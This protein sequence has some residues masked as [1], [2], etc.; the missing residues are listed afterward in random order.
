[1]S[2]ASLIGSQIEESRRLEEAGQMGVALKCA[3]SALEQARQAG[4]TQSMAAAWARIAGIH[5]R[6]GHYARMRLA[7]RQ[8]YDSSGEETQARAD[9]LIMLGLCAFETDS[10]D[11]AEACFIEAGDLCRQI[12]Y[13]SSHFRALHNV[14]CIYGL[15]G[16]F[17]LAI[18]A[19][20]EAYRLGCEIDSPQKAA[21]LIATCNYYLS[22]G[23]LQQ[24]RLILDEL[25]TLV[26]DEKT[27]QGY[28][29][30][31]TALLALG[32]DDFS[33]VEHL[34]QQSYAIAEKIGDP[35]LKVFTGIGM[36]QHYLAMGQPAPA[37]EWAQEAV[38]CAGRKGT[39]RM[40]GRAL[41]ER[42]RA[43]WMNND[44]ES[45]Q[46][47]FNRAIQEFEDRQQ[48]Y[49]LAR[50]RFFLATFLHSR[51]HSQAAAAFQEAARL[52]AEGNYAYILER[53][54]QLA[55]P[56]IAAYLNHPSVEISQLSAGLLEQLEKIPP[57]P[58]HIFILGAFKVY[59]GKRLIPA[60]AW[61]R[62][63]AG[64]L[65]RLLLVNP[66]R[67]LFREQVVETLWPDAAP[68][69]GGDIYHQ[70]T[71]SLRRALEPDLPDKF[72]SRYVFVDEGRVS[73]RLPPG[74]EVDFETFERQIK[75]EEHEAAL[76]IYQGEPFTEDRYRDWASWKREQLA[77]KYQQAL[78]TVAGQKLA[79]GEAGEALAACQRLLPE[80][81][82]CEPAVLLAMQACLQLNDRPRALRLY[83]QLET[84]LKDELQILPAA[85][86]QELYRSLI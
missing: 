28:L 69:T 78:L 76:E 73:L 8:A 51:R 68:T 1:M 14:A 25:V 32:E 54:R 7:A 12:D 34:F 9:A 48:R 72:P 82:W 21:A 16:Q 29:S 27:Y 84:R 53:E 67:S 37:L 86:L 4:D 52:I 30:M 81:P 36:C 40:L 31:L 11:E 44:L 47:D 23:D 33:C 26:G 59:R 60:T 77:Q 19:D 39:R 6:M 22:T 80:N 55:F 17:G 56:M 70:A 61:K 24:A 66:G 63:H 20:R 83:R 74:S 2:V 57:E 85:E 38:S 65:F 62:R 58:L 71:S 50:A 64:E 49:D 46:T 43:A 35:A 79:A 75:N 45:A 15:R 42:G 41:I 3:N 10:L 18:A 13:P 5:Y